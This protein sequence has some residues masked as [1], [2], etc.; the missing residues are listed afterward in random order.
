MTG[1]QKREERQCENRQGRPSLGK[2]S[3]VEEEEP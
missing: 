2:R 1:W 3:E